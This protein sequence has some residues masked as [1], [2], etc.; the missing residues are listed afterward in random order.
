LSKS[1][2]IRFMAACLISQSTDLI[3]GISHPP[4]TKNPDPSV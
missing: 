1:Q 3:D 2:R 4:P